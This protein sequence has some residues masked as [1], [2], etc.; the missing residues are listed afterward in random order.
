[1]ADVATQKTEQGALVWA[2]GSLTTV[3]GLTRSVLSRGLLTLPS[4]QEGGGLVSLVRLTAPEIPM[5][6][7]NEGMLY[8]MH[9]HHECFRLLWN[10]WINLDLL[11]ESCGFSSS[12]LSN[13]CSAALSPWGPCL[14]FILRQIFQPHPPGQGSGKQDTVEDPRLRVWIQIGQWKWSKLSEHLG[15]THTPLSPLQNRG[16]WWDTQGCPAQLW[17]QEA[18]SGWNTPFLIHGWPL[19]L[20]WLT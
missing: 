18:A 15:I 9:I 11:L 16:V 1:M 10:S 7:R 8:Y 6:L 13:L 20:F 4:L 3:L 17:A 12:P 19:L 14:G 5:T 2:P